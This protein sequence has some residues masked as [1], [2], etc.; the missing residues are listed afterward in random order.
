MIV[1]GPEAVIPRE[2]QTEPT[3]EVVIEPEYFWARIE[4]RA[5]EKTLDNRAAQPGTVAAE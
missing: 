2:V 1:H 5:R 3:A 4:R